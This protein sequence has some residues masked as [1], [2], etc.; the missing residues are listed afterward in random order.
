M[1]DQIILSQLQCEAA[2]AF[3][4]TLFCNLFELA[5]L[6]M[7]QVHLG[8]AYPVNFDLMWPGCAIIAAI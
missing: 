3:L 4:N 8:L 5:Y 2:G 6:A 7:L 1:K